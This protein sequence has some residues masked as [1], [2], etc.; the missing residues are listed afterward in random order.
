M[1]TD[2]SRYS[3]P[4]MA[5]TLFKD[6]FSVSFFLLCFG[7]GRRT[8]RERAALYLH[9]FVV[10]CERSG[11]FTPLMRSGIGFLNEFNDYDTGWTNLNLAY[12]NLFWN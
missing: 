4:K 9:N 5:T 7:P 8:C 3:F 10:L 1:K 2:C 11:I 12:Y 6:S